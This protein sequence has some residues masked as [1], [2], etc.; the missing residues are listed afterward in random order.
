LLAILFV[1][2]RPLN[3]LFDEI[4]DQSHLAFTEARSIDR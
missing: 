3:F 2:V 4:G 1:L